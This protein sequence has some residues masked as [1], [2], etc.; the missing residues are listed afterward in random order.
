[1]KPALLIAGILYLVLFAVQGQYMVI[2]QGGLQDY[3]AG[4]RMLL[5]SAHIYAMLCAIPCILLGLYLPAKR[6]LRW[7]ERGISLLFLLSPLIMF[8]GY[9]IESDQ[10]FTLERPLIRYTLIALYFACAML[11]I[12]H[13]LAQRQSQKTGSD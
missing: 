10:G 4:H 11:P 7:Y 13:G 3:P 8:V 5:R 6:S 1:M 12:V 2:F 9:F